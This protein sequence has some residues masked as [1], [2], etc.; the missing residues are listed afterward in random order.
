MISPSPRPRRR[1][2][3]MSLVLSAA[4]ASAQA[5]NDPARGRLLFNDTPGVSGINTLP[6]SCVNCHVSVQDRRLAIGGNAFADISLS[7]AMTRFQQAVQNR[8]EM[9]AFNALDVQDALDIAAYIADTPKTSASELDFSPSAINTATL[10]QTVTLTNSIATTESLH[11]LGVTIS[12]TGASRFTRTSD[13]CDLQTIGPGASC[14]VQVSFSAPDTA[15]SMPTLKFALRQGSATT[16]FERTVVLTGAVED[17]PAPA[18]APSPD[19]GGGALG[20]E[21]LAG[22]AL[23]AHLLARK[24]SRT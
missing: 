21:W 12:G 1:A 3:L 4:A 6:G 23:A 11:V 9:R 19:S 18:P 22:L 13:L 7:T 24:R 8:P 20:F 5:A 17:A 14:N 15:V 16:S 10:P 2:A